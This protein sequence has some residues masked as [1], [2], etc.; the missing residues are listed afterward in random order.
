MSEHS[1][2]EPML[3]ENRTGIEWPLEQARISARYGIDIRGFSS[4]SEAHDVTEILNALAGRTGFARIVDRRNRGLVY[5]GT[6]D[7]VRKAIIMSALQTKD[8]QLDVCV[9]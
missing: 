2:I 3:E 4:H 7:D 6:V 1:D 8:V 9:P 5:E